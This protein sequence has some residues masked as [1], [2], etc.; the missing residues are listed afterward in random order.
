MKTSGLMTY[1]IAKVCSLL[2]IAALVLHYDHTRDL[3]KEL[4]NI[5]ILQVIPEKYLNSVLYLRFL[6]S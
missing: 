5:G 3:S 4:N 2:L 6:F 1:T